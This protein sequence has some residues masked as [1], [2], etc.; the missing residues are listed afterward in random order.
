MNGTHITMYI[1]NPRI[2]LCNESTMTSL[3]YDQICWV[4]NT[5]TAAWII[6]LSALEKCRSYLLRSCWSASVRGPGCVTPPWTERLLLKKKAVK[7]QLMFAADHADK[8]GK[9]PTF[10][11]KVMWWW[12]I[13]WAAVL[14]EGVAFNPKKTVATV[15]R[16]GGNTLLW[17]RFC[18]Q[19]SWCFKESEWE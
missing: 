16:R 14:L 4:K 1:N 18:C 12:K 5:H 6:P 10:Q 8:G 3:K 15:R 9:K 19:W 2:W 13:Q 7:I 11:R 17:G